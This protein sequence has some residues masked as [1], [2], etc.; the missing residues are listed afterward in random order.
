MSICLAFTHV[1]LLSD[2]K[3]RILL[4]LHALDVWHAH[5]PDHDGSLHTRVFCA[6]GPGG[7]GELDTSAP[8][9]H[10][11]TQ[12]G[13]AEGQKEVE[14]GVRWRGGGRTMALGG[15]AADVGAGDGEVLAWV[16]SYVIH[17]LR[18]ADH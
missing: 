11:S 9:W 10:I 6:S 4:A 17:L 2:L 1:A 16:D 13:E 3:L 18:E 12:F 15:E 5:P 8:F 7:A 14:R